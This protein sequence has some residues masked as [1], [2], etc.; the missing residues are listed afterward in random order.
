MKSQLA[1][2]ALALA[3]LMSPSSAEP[4]RVNASP[5]VGQALISMTSP[6]KA[7]NVDLKPTREDS[8]PAA[9]ETLI[10]GRADVVI[11]VRGLKAEERA[12]APGKQLKE[13]PI[14]LHAV[15]LLVSPDVWASG[16]RSM[17]K[18]KLRGIYQKEITNWKEV[19]GADLPITFYSYIKGKGVWEQFAVWLYGELRKAPLSKEEPLATGSDARDT[20]AFAKGAM[21]IASPVWANGKDAYAIAIEDEKGTPIEPSIPMLSSRRYPMARPVFAIFGDKPVGVRARFLEYLLSPEGQEILKKN[22][23]TPIADLTAE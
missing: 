20:L 10:A 16:V 22:D 7:F 6:L 4:L 12:M 2:F 13:Y 9:I 23:L 5:V 11:T 15:A 14:G 3:T 1:L 18:E 17:S 21:A 8:S 19:G